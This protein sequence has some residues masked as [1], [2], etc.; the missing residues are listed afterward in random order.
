MNEWPKQW[1]ALSLKQKLW[2]NLREEE[3]HRNLCDI[4]KES[5]MAVII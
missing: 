3:S 1:L 5:L 2:V 4:P